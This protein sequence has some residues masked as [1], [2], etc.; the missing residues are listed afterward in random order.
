MFKNFINII[1][2]LLTLTVQMSAVFSAQNKTETTLLKGSV[3]SEVPSGFFGLWRVQAIRIN[4][5][6]PATFKQKNT[7]IWNIS[8]TNNVIKLCNPFT[9]ANAEI[10]IEKSQ[11]DNI[12]FRK[13]GK[14]GNKILTDI[15]KITINGETFEGKNELILK[16]ISEI[17]KR[18]IKTETAEY[19]IKGE[20]VAGESITGN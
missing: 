6:S 4:T 10:T 12:T 20:K 1:F 8:Q 9:G 13:Q 11:K 17:D 18:V 2:I 5:D 16:T 14:Y 7:D 19:K 15:V 3:T